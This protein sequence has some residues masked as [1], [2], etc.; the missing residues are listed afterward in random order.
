MKVLLVTSSYSSSGEGSAAAG[1]FVR[2]FARALTHREVQVDIVAPALGNQ[3]EIDGRLTVR[4]FAVPRLPLALLNPLSPLNWA[5]ILKTMT[6]GRRAVLDACRDGKP[7][8]ILALWAL[9]CGAWAREAA[10][11]F[12]LPY[13]TW[14]LGS[15]IWGL[16]KLPIIRNRL[17]SVLR[18]ATVCFA[19]GIA[20]ATDVQEISGRECLF[21]PSS[22]DFGRPPQRLPRTAPPYRL[23]FLGR[24]HPNKGPDL[25]LDA[26]T[27][28]TP[29]EWS[30]IEAV[31]VCGG[32]PL[33]A[34][35][36][37][38]AQA[39]AADGKP[40]QLGGFLDHAA[41]YSLFEWADYVVIPSRIESIPVVFSDAMQAHRPVIAAP[42]GD[43]PKLI[44]TYACGVLATEVSPAGIAAAIRRALATPPGQFLRGLGAAADA[45]SVQG[46]ADGFLNTVRAKVRS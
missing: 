4:R 45:F 31:R 13:G 2:D 3:L 30:M 9:P 35:L 8:L 25:L 39:L 32:G 29:K 24:W 42:V 37:A 38:R 16:G 7:D 28:L 19:D 17:A 6:A 34:E 10:R 21:L 46:A 18:D 14:A 43:I 22:R 26:L 44:E 12:S 1:V 5:P 41:A 36:R 15:D 23:A 33:E 20:L 40:I 27:Q 11:R